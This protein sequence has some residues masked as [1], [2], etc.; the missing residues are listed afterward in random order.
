MD[1]LS[2]YLPADRRQ[3]LAY[4][5]TLPDRVQGAALF[6][7][8]SGFT[9]LAEALAHTLGPQRGA[10]ELPRQLN[11]VYDA[12][13]AELDRYGGSVIG[14]SGDA[15]TCWFDVEGLPVGP[16]WVGGGG[17]DGGQ[18]ESGQVESSPVECPPAEK[19]LGTFQLQ[20]LAAAGLRATACGLA[21]QQAM[22]Q[23]GALEISGYG[24]VGLA[25]KVGIAVGSARR[26]LVGDPTIQVLEVLAGETLDR[27]AAAE[28]QANKGEVILEP[29]AARLLGEWLEVTDWR[30]DKP[31]IAEDD[32]EPGHYAVVGGLRVPVAPTPWPPLPEA[33]PEEL[34]RPWLLQPV[35]ERLQAGQGEFLAELRPAV[36]LFLG[37]RGI[38]YDHD[39]QAGQQL[40]HYIRWVQQVAARYEGTLMDITMG[41]KGS[42]LYLAFGAPIAH[43]DDAERAA[44]VALELRQPPPDLPISHIQLGLNRGRMR[45]GAYGGVTRRTYGVLGDE[46]N[47]AARLMGKAEP[48]QIMVS[49]RV[50]GVL[51]E[52]FLLQTVGLIGVKGKQTQIPV[53]LLLERRP[54]VSPQRPA[55]LYAHP[56]V[57]RE[58]ELA[59]FSS[60]LTAAQR[61]DGQ[62]LRL[63]GVPGI[64][65]S[66]LA[67]ELVEQALQRGFQ[68]AVGTCHSTTQGSP[69]LPWRQ[70]LRAL[71]GLGPDQEA[72]P[73]PLSTQHYEVVRQPPLGSLVDSA[74]SPEVARLQAL[75]AETNPDWLVRLPLLGEL[76]GVPVAENPTTAA[77]DPRLR[78]EALLALVVEM[79]Q[80]WATRQPL[81]FMIEDAHW[82]DEASLGLTLALGRAIGGSTHLAEAEERLPGGMVLVLVH[83]P[84]L[85][86]DQPLLPELE[87]L[88]YHQCLTLTE[89]SAPG[90]AALAINCLGGPAAPLALSLIEARSHGNPFFIEELVTAL[91]ETGQLVPQDD[92]CWEL[93]P[94]LIAALREARLLVQ[95]G[96]HWELVARQHLPPTLLGL[97]DS[98]HGIVLARIDRLPEAHKLTLKVASVIGRV[99]PLEV[100]IP[101]HPLRPSHAALI[102]QIELLQTRDFTMIELPGPT[103]VYLFKH[104]VTQEVAYTTLLFDQ[105]RQLHTAVA[106][107]YEQRFGAGAPLVSETLVAPNELP[108]AL[109]SPL[110]AHY[111]LLVHHWH[112]AEDP[113]RERHYA[114]LAGQQA[115]AQYANEAAS[116]YF[117]RVLA[118]TPASNLSARAQLLL[119]HEAVEDRR[120]NR[121]AQARD[122]SALI[123]V[124]EALG[125]DQLR[126]EVSLRRANYAVSL[127]DYSAAETAVQES[128]RYATHAKASSVET[129]GHI[130]AGRITMRQGRYEHART[131]L[132]QALTLA[133]SASHHDEEAEGMLLLGHLCRFQGATALAQSYAYKALE[134]YRTINQRVGEIG[135]LN[136]LGNVAQAIGDHQIALEFRHQALLICQMIGHRRGE[137]SLLLNL[138][139]A[140]FDLGKYSEAV[141]TLQRNLIICREIGDRVV[142]APSFD[143][144]G[145]SYLRLGDL[146]AAHQ[147]LQQALGIQREIGDRHN[148]GYGLT[149]LGE[150]LVTLEDLPGATAAYQQ[151][152]NIRLELGER[153][154]AI[155]DLTGLAWVALTQG[156]TLQA[157]E[158]VQEI[159][160]WVETQGLSGIEFPS[161]AYLICYR[162]LQALAR[163]D[164]PSQERASIVLATAHDLLQ[165]QAARIRDE[166]LRHSFLENVPA[167][168]EI[169]AEWEAHQKAR[170]QA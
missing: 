150:L 4:G 13:I 96:D 115:S 77:F 154:L 152:L 156:L 170:G 17:G 147:A 20:P 66:H 97:P 114:W 76:L 59:R 41:D 166:E 68:V 23:F 109:A 57:G 119:A 151:A 118:L 42:Y 132:E 69:Y 110:A 113:A 71:L 22:R 9:P 61:G 143:T 46:V 159:L 120:G 16:L 10:E 149:H 137:A 131:L 160:A 5:H 79:V 78:Q 18:V 121:A 64:G 52:H 98:I 53:S 27:M 99:F 165:K 43:D 122:L 11:R 93:S 55:S 158:Y 58:P 133:Q 167:N 45:T 74:L 39:E 104:N 112:Y 140:L 21:M 153:E 24:T 28:R 116:D 157:S 33:F 38:D 72:N 130:L 56:L 36:A 26:F 136:L 73:P 95:T 75:V 25:V 37:F 128:L 88:P 54:P 168:R 108:A 102:E 87:R 106:R 15:V 138:G 62:I 2:A 60:V 90:V 145:I 142:E 103:P 47:L 67:A 30:A 32:R 101:T 6:A 155:D 89:L 135:S 82:L 139:N 86:E 14:F 126:A 100:L 111:P 80:H 124:A 40:D 29:Q 146:S 123:E 1:T 65:K 129:K 117:S 49:E 107:W 50:T 127:S 7:D 48:G 91:R 63:E 19:E 35:Y 162:V 44:A 85:R 92:G 169:R 134:Y 94:E 105:R 144:L 31:P 148:E 163:D 3:A 8:I 51:G 34:L 161:L 83:R 84:A 125:D 12:L 141:E 81:L 164:L 70:A